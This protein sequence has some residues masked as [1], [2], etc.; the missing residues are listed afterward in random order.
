M[1]NKI[2][3][4]MNQLKNVNIVNN[5]EQVKE[6]IKEIFEIS[7]SLSIAIVKDPKRLQE[8]YIYKDDSIVPNGTT[9]VAIAP[10]VKTIKI[11]SIPTSVQ[12]LLLLDGFNVQLKEDG[13]NKKT[14]NN[15]WSV[16]SVLIFPNDFFIVL[17][18]AAE[19][20]G[21]AMLGDGGVE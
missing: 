4:L 3:E 11:G 20:I 14:C 2:K 10:S 15:W 19:V 6:S 18:I 9:Y 5:S 21:V 12:Y 17:V 13:F 16:S 7:D 1:K 8:C